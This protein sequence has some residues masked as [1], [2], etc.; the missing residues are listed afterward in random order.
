MTPAWEKQDLNSCFQNKVS[1]PPPIFPSIPLPPLFWEPRGKCF[2][3]SAGPGDHLLAGVTT[4]C[5]RERECQWRAAAQ[6]MREYIRGPARASGLTSDLGIRVPAGW[7]GL[8][9]WSAIMLSFGVTVL[10]EGNISGI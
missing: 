7:F 4:G 9:R 2:S 3:P 1:T 10:P 8:G 6:W 5:V